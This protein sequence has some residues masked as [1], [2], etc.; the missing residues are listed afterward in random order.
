MVSVAKY[1]GGTVV[2]VG[3]IF[4]H[5]GAEGLDLWGDSKKEAIRDAEVG[6]E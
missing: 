1:L 2:A 3:N 6:A 5:G 4:P